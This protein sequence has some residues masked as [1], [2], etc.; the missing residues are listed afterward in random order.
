MLGWRS[1][2]ATVGVNVELINDAV[3]NLRVESA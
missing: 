2:E 1:L 3:L